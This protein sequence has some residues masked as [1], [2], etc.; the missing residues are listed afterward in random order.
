MTS[1]KRLRLMLTE[2]M[3]EWGRICDANPQDERLKGAS[4]EIDRIWAKLNKEHGV[5]SLDMVLNE[6]LGKRDV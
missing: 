3:I 5:H 1:K 6:Y 4:F 2:K